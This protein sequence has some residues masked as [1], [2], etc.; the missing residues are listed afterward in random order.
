MGIPSD[1]IERARSAL[2][3][4]VVAERGIRLRGTIDRYGPCPRCGG[5]DRFEHHVRKIF[6]CRGCGAKGG[7][8]DL[9]MHID[10][11]DSRRLSHGSQGPWARQRERQAL[12][13]PPPAQRPLT[14]APPAVGSARICP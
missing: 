7:V 14:I 1:Q 8:I 2:V 6:N 13:M 9:V 10:R 4:N 12:P 11:C 3:E 5:V